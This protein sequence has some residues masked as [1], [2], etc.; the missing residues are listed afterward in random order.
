MKKYFCFMFLGF[1]LMNYNGLKSE[2]VDSKGRTPLH[3]ALIMQCLPEKLEMLLNAGAHESVNVVDSEGRTPLHWALIMQCSL[4]KLEML[5]NAGAHESVN[6]VD[7]EGRTPLHWALIMQH[8][9]EKLKMLLNAGAHESVNVVDREGR[10]PLHWAL[11]RQCLPEELEMLLN[12]GADLSVLDKNGKIP[13]NYCSDKIKK[14]IIMNFIEKLEES[15]FDVKKLADVF[16][17]FDFSDKPTLI[18]ELTEKF[19]SISLE[20]WFDPCGY[21]RDSDEKLTSNYNKIDDEEP[22]TSD[23]DCRS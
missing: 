14:M 17:K 19:N 3:W 18:G 6:V 20:N 12:A 11:I 13:F 5:L 4:E 22:K 9:L 1:G 10:T 15:K 21:W 7:S 8:S 2:A 23:Y 16:D